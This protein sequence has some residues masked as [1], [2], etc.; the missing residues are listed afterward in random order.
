MGVWSRCP[1]TAYL[2]SSPWPARHILQAFLNTCFF[3][4][5]SPSR[6]S[7]DFTSYQFNRP[8]SYALPP[9]PAP[10]SRIRLWPISMHLFTCGYVAREDT[11]DGQIGKQELLK[12][13]C[14]SALLELI[15]PVIIKVYSIISGI[16]NSWLTDASGARG[17]D[18]NEL[19]LDHSCLWDISVCHTTLDFIVF[20]KILQ[21]T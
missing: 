5:C 13:V 18:S 15:K 14:D 12:P 17:H 4:I 10:S 7:V 3:S 2:F 16:C 19:N 9:P 11:D 6:S 8:F 20:W 1:D 21:E